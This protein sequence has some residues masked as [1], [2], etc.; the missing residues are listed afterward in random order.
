MITFLNLNNWIK[1]L[2]PVTSTDYLTKGGEFHTEGL[3]SETI[4]GS[5]G[6]NDRR[7]IF[8]YIDLY[9]KVIHPQALK[10][11]EQLDGKIKKFISTEST[12]SLDENGMLQEDENGVTGINEFINLYPKIKF[13]GGTPDREK[14]IKLIEK[15][16][17]EDVLFIDKLPIIPPYNRDAHKDED[18]QWSIDPLNEIYLVIM[19]RS[20]N[21]RSVTGFGALYD[22]LNYGLQSSVNE[23]HEFIRTK[24]GKKQGI[25]RKEILSKRVDFT[26]RAVITPNPEL[27][28]NEIGVPLRLAV[29]VF[30]PFII[31]QIL[32][33]NLIDK[34]VLEK[35]IID[36]TGLDMSVDSIKKVMKSIKSSDDVPKSL[37]DLF[38]K[39]AVAAAHNR[40]VI[41]KRDPSLHAE[42]VRAYIPVIINGNT[43]Q[44]CTMQ[45]GG[46][47][48]DF[49][50]DT[51]AIFHPLTDESQQEAKDKMLKATSGESSTKI[52]FDISKEMCLGLYIMTKNKPTKSSP[53]VITEEDIK[54]SNNPYTPV[55]YKN[56]TTTMGKAVFNWCLPKDYPFIDD[57]ITKGKANKI[58]QDITEKYGDDTARESASRMEK[59]GFKYATIMGSSIT[60]DHIEIPQSIYSLKQKLD[61]ASIDEAQIILDKMLQLLKVHL[62]DTGLA[63]LSNSGSTK[64]WGQPF[65][66]LVA[67]GIIADPEG[68]ILP[69]IA[70][71]LA[72]G[73]KPKDYFNASM[74]A[75]KGIIDR[76][77]NTADTGYLSRKL[78]FT[79]N[80]VVASKY[81]RDCKTTKTLSIKLT[82]DII[83][84]LTGRYMMV[85]GKLDEI[86]INELKSGQLIELRSPI[87]CQSPEL[88]LACYGKLIQRHKSPY[89]GV[90]AAQI[91]GELGTQLIMRT[92]HTGGAVTIKQ[93]DMLGDIIDNDPLIDID[94][95][96]LKKYLKQDMSNLICNEDCELR[97]D[98]SNYSESKNMDIKDD[99]VWVNS[100][101]GV[102]EFEDK[103]FNIVLDYSVDLQI[104][105]LINEKG[106]S[107]IFKYNKD[108][109]IFNISAEFL[110]MTEKVL[111][112]QRLLAGKEVF[113]DVNHLFTKL[114]RE[115]ADISGMDL[116]HLEV[117]LGNCLRDKSNTS[118]PAR[119]GKPWDPI[120]MDIKKVVFSGGFVQG[121]AFEN[122]GAAIKTG[123]I[124]EHDLPPSILEQIVTGTLISEKK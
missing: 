73:L 80:T 89:V 109:I 19:R 124:S 77:I 28:V 111:Y 24:I 47:N 98:M 50:G 97:I 99:S 56:K 101:I 35:E 96:Q 103:I 13:R 14:Y 62:E 76:V 104:Q 44:M 81:I 71:S 10:I 60:L 95:T 52:T 116:V 74:G 64:G 3:F 70:G 100:L 12:Y 51:M 1:G 110:E 102:I 43:L 8:S 93:R 66:M 53:I 114:F 22:V 88:C 20:F 78:A 61:G 55:I 86:N 34:R 23:H 106:K 107:L 117:L 16:Y 63:D 57:L 31:H 38:F 85:N 41:A 5:E 49:D 37:Y 91:I 72:D 48:A 40:I 112:V 115:Y 26:A 108:S 82:K 59:S 118:I 36:Y 30:E 54:N 11:L 79:L 4:F 92:F 94:K 29:G 39:A 87:Y 2:T 46:H 15:A 6:A 119:L 90:V 105:E 45:V 32:Y 42:S 9:A 7:Q 68:N 21:V 25:I 122:V 84:R 18:G 120:L 83:R 113:K 121:L 17:K 58:L 123:L 75:R 67:K 65:Q 33:T 27:K 69:V